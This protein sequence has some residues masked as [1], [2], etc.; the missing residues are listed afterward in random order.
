MIRLIRQSDFWIN[1][2]ELI[3]TLFASFF[4]SV[5]IGRLLEDGPEM[6]PV[7]AIRSHLVQ[8]KAEG[9]EV[10][11]VRRILH[12]HESLAYRGQKVELSRENAWESALNLLQA[13]SVLVG[14]LLVADLEEEE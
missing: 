10:L 2:V 6:F 1:F 8:V 7:V 14:F 3:Q 5:R 12:R 11:I 13:E 9:L 4:L